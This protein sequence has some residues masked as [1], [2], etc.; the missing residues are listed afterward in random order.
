MAEHWFCK[1]AVI[2]S[3][4]IFGFMCKKQEEYPK[5][6]ISI[7]GFGV[8]CQCE[9]CG[10]GD[11]EISLSYEDLCNNLENCVKEAFCPICKKQG[12][13]GSVPD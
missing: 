5:E 6:G 9:N 12:L 13:I 2:S 11:I 4:L 7:V 1:P 10:M 3:T 8:V